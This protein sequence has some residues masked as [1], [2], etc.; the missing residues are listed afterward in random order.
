[1]LGLPESTEYGKRIPKNKFYKHL[2]VT[3]KIERAFID[4]IDTIIW[5][6][7]LSPDTI[8][9]S[10]TDTVKEIQVIE[11]KLKEK[12]IDEQ[13]L[14]FIDRELKWHIIFVL[15]F[16]GM[17]QVVIGYKQ[18]SERVSDIFKVDTYFYSEWGSQ[19]DN[20]INVTGLTLEELYNQWLL[21]LIP[22]KAREDESIQQLIERYKEIKGL[23]RKINQLAL[24]MKSENQFNKKV[25]LNQEIKEIKSSLMK[26]NEGKI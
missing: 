19:D 8:N 18:E 4:Q 3:P 26:L 17:Q 2:K 25:E 5:Q 24:Q 20:R 16:K 12:R 22:L 14:K 11:I 15:S 7:K 9:L 6:N 1:M 23:E 13:V 21:E 10:A